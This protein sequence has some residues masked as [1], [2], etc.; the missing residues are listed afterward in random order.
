MPDT[1]GV[2]LISQ[3]DTYLSQISI[4]SCVI[5]IYLKNAY[6]L[7]NGLECLLEKYIFIFKSNP[8]IIYSVDENDFQKPFWS[9][10]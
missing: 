10:K 6:Y 2:I 4:H 3:E 8:H 7:P 9:I 1:S 5:F